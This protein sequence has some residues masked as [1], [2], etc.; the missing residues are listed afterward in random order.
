M[1]AFLREP[2][3][4]R[5]FSH[6]FGTLYTAVLRPT[7]RLVEYH[8]P[9]TSWSQSIAGFQEGERTVTL[10]PARDEGGIRVPWRALAPA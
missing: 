2:V 10:L 5:N 8:W 4:G 9:D 1:D 6:G 7:E 3:Y